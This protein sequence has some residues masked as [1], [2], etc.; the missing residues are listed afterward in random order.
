M[1]AGN[2]CLLTIL[3][4]AASVLV[5]SIH[6]AKPGESVKKGNHYLRCKARLGLSLSLP[7]A[8]M[9]FPCSKKREERRKKYKQ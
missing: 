1:S 6:Q 4:R 3:L 7:E 2:Q 5:I 9:L 8:G